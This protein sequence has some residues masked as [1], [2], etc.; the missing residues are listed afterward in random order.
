M[1]G[2][3]LAM[4]AASPDEVNTVTRSIGYDML[5]ITTDVP[6]DK[7]A[8]RVFERTVAMRNVNYDNEN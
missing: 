7:R 3:R 4:L 8:R 5:D 2:I 1:Q 6:T